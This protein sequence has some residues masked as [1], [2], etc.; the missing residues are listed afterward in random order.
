MKKPT[1]EQEDLA[2]VAGHADEGFT[3]KYPTLAEY[4]TT[5][6][7][8]GGGVR[9]P[10]AISLSIKDGLWQAALNDKALK[11]SLYSSAATLAEALKALEGALAD[12]VGAWR[13][14]KRGK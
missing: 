14:W 6:A 8:E 13:P 1:K 9:E 7:W 5:Q 11:Q 3:K 10:S 2:A 12:G 4:M